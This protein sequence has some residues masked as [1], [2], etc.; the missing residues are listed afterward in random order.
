MMHNVYG[1]GDIL[2]I[3]YRY[4]HSM[5]QDLTLCVMTHYSGSMLVRCVRR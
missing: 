3:I 2:I 1:S 4:K 5:R